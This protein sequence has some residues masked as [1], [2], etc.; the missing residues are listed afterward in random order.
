VKEEYK[1]IKL[2]DVKNKVLSISIISSLF[3]FG[4][5][6][7]HPFSL[8]FSYKENIIENEEILHNGDTASS[9]WELQFTLA[10][11]S[12]PEKTQ[13][14]ECHKKPMC[15]IEE[16]QKYEIFYKEFISLAKEY[17]LPPE[18]HR[19][20]L[21]SSKSLLPYFG[22]ENVEDWSVLVHFS[23]CPNCSVMLRDG[24]ELRSILVNH[25]PLVKEVNFN[26]L[27]FLCSFS[28]FFVGSE[29]TFI[30]YMLC[31]FL[32][33]LTQRLYFQVV[34]P[35]FCYLLIHRLNLQ[36]VG[37]KANWRLKLSESMQGKIIN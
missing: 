25:H 19:F 37:Q 34:G 12:V 21:V 7:N 11:Q 28:I 32:I 17:F 22:V 9:A 15:T 30:S 26:F 8:S 5:Y 33:S 2:L 35:P 3:F 27:F 4:L 1:T 29:I 23:G 10:N 16:F 20:S 18:R 6:N 24:D 14:G 13:N 36:K 31:F